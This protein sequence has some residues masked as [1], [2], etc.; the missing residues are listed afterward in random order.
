[1]INISSQAL[2]LLAETA[3][4]VG[5][6]TAATSYLDHHCSHHPQHH[7]CHHYH[8]YHHHFNHHNV[9]FCHH[10]KPLLQLVILIIV[11]LIIISHM[12]HLIQR[13]SLRFETLFL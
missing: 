1:M 5:K 4:E 2:G 8:N 12:P 7:H 6:A 13:I 3:L 10:Q 9:N 11:V